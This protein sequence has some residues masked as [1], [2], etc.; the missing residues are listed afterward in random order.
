MEIPA[1][2]RPYSMAVAPDS[3]RKKALSF[4]SMGQAIGSPCK[5]SVKPILEIRTE[6][7]ELGQDHPPIGTNRKLGTFPELFR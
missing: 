1:A 5:A 2:I 6:R 7:P 3:S 4:A